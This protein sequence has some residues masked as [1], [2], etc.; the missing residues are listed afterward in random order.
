MSNLQICCAAVVGSLFLNALAVGQDTVITSTT[1]DPAARVKK[2]GQILDYTGTELTL[3]TT[4][5]GIWE[6][7]S[8]ALMKRYTDVKAA[9]PAAIAQANAVVARATAMAPTL[10]HYGV[11]LNIPK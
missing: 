7:P 3:K 11:E 4:F 1:G 6:T 9:L 10:K 5:G 8:D 2:Q